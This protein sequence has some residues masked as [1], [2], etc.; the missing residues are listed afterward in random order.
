[1]QKCV[2]VRFSLIRF[3]SS[4]STCL[5]LSSSVPSTSC[6]A[7]CILSSTTWSPCKTCAPPRT[8][9]V[10]TPTTST[11]P[12]QVMSPTTWSGFLVLRY[13]VIGPGHRR[14]YARQSC[15]PKHAENMP[16]TAIRN[17]CLSVSRRRLLCSIEQGN[18]REKEMSINQLVL[19]SQETRTVLKASFPK[20]PELRKWSIHQG[21]LM[22][23]IAQRTD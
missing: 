19:A 7:S 13:P 8:R 9:G 5:S 11:P 18:L 16:I 22:S 20:T 1:M 23:E 6:T 2:H 21:K 10:T 17:A 12:S 3:S 4:T 14:R 15:S